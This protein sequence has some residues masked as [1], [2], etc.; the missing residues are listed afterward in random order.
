MDDRVGRQ[1]GNYRL[2]RF[3]G[4]GGF[5]EVYLGEHIY[6]ETQAA[7]KVLHTQLAS[8][9]IEQFRGEARTIARLIHPHI[10]RVLEF[11]VEGTTPFLVMDYAPNGTLRQRYPKGT[12]IPLTSVVSYVTQIAAALQYAH[13]QRLIHRDIKPENLLVGRNN[14]ILLS[15]FGIALVTQSSRY[16]STRDMAGTIAY[17]AP[18]QIEAHPRPASDQYSLGI[19]VYE[20]L[21][22]DRPFHGSFTE[23]AIKH[24]LVPPPSLR[25]KVPT[26]S[27]DVEQV[28]MTALAKDPKQRFGS[29]Q[30]FATALEQASRVAFGM[31]PPLGQSPQPTELVTPPRQTAFVTEVV[32]P[33]S[34]SSQP[35]VPV[36]PSSQSPWSPSDASLPNESFSPSTMMPLRNQSSM[37]SVPSQPSQRGISRRAMVIGLAGMAVVGVVGGG[38]AWLTH[39]QRPQTSSQISPPS[40]P[41]TITWESEYDGTGVYAALVD[42]FNKTNKDNIH[43]IYNNG[44]VNT[45]DLRTQFVTAFR[46]RNGSPDV[47]SMDIIWPAEFAANQWIIP[48][49]DKWPASER[50]NYFPGPLAGCT[51]NGHVVAAPL[52]M[53]AGLI[54]YRNDIISSAPSTWDDMTNMAKSAQSKV[55]YGYVWQGAQYEGLVC[56]FVEV[57]YGYGGSVLDPNNPKTVTVNSA[58]ANAALT[59]MVNW[60]GGISPTAITAYME[61]NARTTFENGDAAFMRNWPYAYAL[62]NDASTSKVAGK[63]GVHLM[64]YGGSNTTGHSC[65]GGWQLGINAFSKNPD[66]AWKFI[67]YM[68][69]PAAQKQIALQASLTVT[70]LNIYDDPDVLLKN[71]FFG[72]LKPVFQTALPRPVTPKYPDVA[73]AIQLRVH[74]ALT[75]QSSVSAALTALESDLK[76]IVAS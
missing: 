31:T 22:G 69:S 67:H 57:L 64:L 60:V 52:R 33:S 56:D 43:V 75:K 59:R 65:I 39:A 7:I 47:I 2:I 53:E 66:A 71:P 76:S 28:V 41:T 70:L 6:L 63:I 15:D 10:V 50:A 68:L 11:G 17:M 16:Q 36:I 27:T 51:F 46:A 72:N 29:V 20:W 3:L 21:S 74:Q 13:N 40:G 32:P 23:I 45:G 58:E 34:Q 12:R 37:V 42:S 1:L 30:A 35:A 62:G 44:P 38:V 73:T 54:Y 8:D 4:Q 18:E 55:K 48:L 9:D 19:V 25:E 24:T 14:E 26:L 49:D 5:A 61:E